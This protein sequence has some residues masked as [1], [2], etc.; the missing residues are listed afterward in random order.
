MTTHLLI[1]VGKLSNFN[2]YSFELPFWMWSHRGWDLPL[3]AAILIISIIKIKSRC[4]ST[5]TRIFHEWSDLLWYIDFL[6]FQCVSQSGWVALCWSFLSPSAPPSNIYTWVNWQS[7]IGQSTIVGW[8]S[9][10]DHWLKILEAWNLIFFSFFDVEERKYKTMHIYKSVQVGAIKLVY[11]CLLPHL[12]LPP[13]KAHPITSPIWGVSQHPLQRTKRKKIEYGLNA[14]PMP[15]RWTKLWWEKH[16]VGF[17][18]RWVAGRVR[19]GWAL[20]IFG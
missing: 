18:S 13:S 16:W 5:N 17:H 7:W 19:L 3:S 9:T 15:G 4:R 14:G 11:C 20:P 10:N 6:L 2:W 1:W 12:S 8:S